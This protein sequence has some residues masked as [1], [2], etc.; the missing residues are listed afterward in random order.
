MRYVV[1]SLAT[2]SAEHIYDTLYCVRGQGENLIKL[3]INLKT[4]KAL[5]SQPLM[6]QIGSAGRQRRCLFLG[7]IRTE[8]A[9]CEP[10]RF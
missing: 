1:T 8:Y 10:F 6:A 7:V 5:G 9:R 4:A 2:G 3:V